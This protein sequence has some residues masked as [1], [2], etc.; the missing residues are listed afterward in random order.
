MRRGTRQACYIFGGYGAYI[1]D[2]EPHLLSTS[3]RC[4]LDANDETSTYTIDIE[5]LQGDS[6][7]YARMHHQVAALGSLIYVVGGEDGDSIFNSV[8]IFDPLSIISNKQWIQ[9]SSMLTQRCNFGLAVLD[10]TTLY[11]LGG[12][13]G[14]DIT[15]R[16][17]EF[18]VKT[19]KWTQ[20]PY[21]LQS[22]CY[23]FA[24]VQLNGLIIC[25][26]GSCIYNLP[27]KTT[28]IFNPK[29][30]QSYLCTNMFEAR[31]FCSACLDEETGKIYVF[32]G[33]DAE[34][35]GLRSAEVYNSYSSQWSTLPPMFFNR[36]SPCAY[37]FGYLIVVFGGRTSLNPHSE[38]LNTAEIFHIQKN[39]WIRIND[40]PL[41]IYGGAAVLR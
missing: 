37:R 15:S 21:S 7:L 3:Y 10:S 31:A 19:G 2:L 33:A 23:G 1:D 9:T 25:I 18:N 20:L 14:A 38:I 30:G 36:I 28:E 16:I 39:S 35:N 17:E 12:H 41:R 11:V 32:G 26:G 8:E 24:C 29:T 34:G 22:P 27:M 13:I 5:Q 4:H 40:V 6:M